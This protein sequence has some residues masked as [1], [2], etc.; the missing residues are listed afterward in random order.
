[1]LSLNY[2][3]DRFKYICLIVMEDQY[4]FRSAMNFFEELL[5]NSTNSCFVT[6]VRVDNRY[7]SC[8]SINSQYFYER[9]LFLFYSF[10]LTRV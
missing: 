10:T 7:Y 6:K 5:N 8:F 9:L 1:M 3:V 4:F 2:I